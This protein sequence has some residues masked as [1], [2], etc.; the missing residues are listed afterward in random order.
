VYH[1]L[2]I[3]ASSEPTSGDNPL[4]HIKAV[5]KRED[6]VVLKL[7]VEDAQKETLWIRQLL[8]DRGKLFEVQ[9]DL[10]GT[11]SGCQRQESR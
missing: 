3:P 4:N 5:A 2:N 11:H 1:W 8:A 9:V 10:T 7:D 6:Y